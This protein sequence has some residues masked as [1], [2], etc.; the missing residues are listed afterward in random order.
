MSP[1]WSP[2]RSSSSPKRSSHTAAASASRPRRSSSSLASPSPSTPHCSR[3]SPDA[4]PAGAGIVSGDGPVFVEA[5]RITREELQLAT[6][7]H[8]MPLEALCYPITPLGLHY[9]LIHY[10]VAD[11]DPDSWS[12]EVTGAVDHPLRL[13]LADLRGRPPSTSVATM[14]CAGNGRALLDPRPLSQPWLLEA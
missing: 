7:N 2:S 6:R 9:L 13:S 10:A 5:D 11:V 4:P 1:P 3:P 8:G 14:E 12:L